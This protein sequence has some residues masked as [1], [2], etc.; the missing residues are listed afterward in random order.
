MVGNNDGAVSDTG[1]LTFYFFLFS[2]AHCVRWLMAFCI[3]CTATAKRLQMTKKLRRRILMRTMMHNA[4]DA[5]N[6]LD[7]IF[8]KMEFAYTI[9]ARIRN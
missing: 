8:Y 7:A 5:N 4:P 9:V 3:S 6:A 1:K 2:C